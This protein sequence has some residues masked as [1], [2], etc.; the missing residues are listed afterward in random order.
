MAANY[1]SDVRFM[2]NLGNGP[3]LDP[4]LTI[5]SDPDVVMDEAT[6]RIVTMSPGTLPWAPSCGFNT[7][8]LV[9]ATSTPTQR[10]T[11]K[12][13][14]QQ[15]VMYDP[16]IA[17]VGITSV[18]STLADQDLPVTLNVSGGPGPFP[19][20]TSITQVTPGMLSYS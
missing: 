12:V 6:A 3:D 1:G 16:R 7:I 18:P 9:N 15:G 5:V 17:S 11:V 14:I 4:M 10:N 8:A 19:S 2:L 13:A 20:V